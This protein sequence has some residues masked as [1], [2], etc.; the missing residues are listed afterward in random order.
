MPPLTDVKDA[1]QLHEAAQRLLAVA[2]A[3]ED[4]S[5][6]LDVTVERAKLKRVKREPVAPKKKKSSGH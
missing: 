4:A 5:Q 6:I 3:M 1:Q 2:R